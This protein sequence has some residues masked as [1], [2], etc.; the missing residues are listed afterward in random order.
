MLFFA[1]ILLAYCQ[2]LFSGNVEAQK[3]FLI[4]A[5]L[6]TRP[7]RAKKLIFGGTI[8]AG[9]VKYEIIDAKLKTDRRFWAKTALRFPKDPEG[10]KGGGT[11]S[12]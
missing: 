8:T 6:G 11:A 10:E 5:L 2:A 9:G 4:W 3:R 1:I 7:Q 12:K